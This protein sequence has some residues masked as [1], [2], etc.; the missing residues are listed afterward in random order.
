MKN[1]C[2]VMLFGKYLRFGM[3]IATLADE[4]TVK[5][6]LDEVILQRRHLL[7]TR[8][9]SGSSRRRSSLYCPPPHYHGPDR[10]VSLSSATLLAVVSLQHSHP[11]SHI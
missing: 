5:I 7:Y 3:A 10:R 2:R 1:G 6:Y 8:K 4:C 11:T 9:I